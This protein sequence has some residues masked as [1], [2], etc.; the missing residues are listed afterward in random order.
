MTFFIITQVIV[1][2]KDDEFKSLLEP[3]QNVARKFKGKV[4]TLYIEA[5]KASV[6]FCRVNH[7]L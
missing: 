1:F 2:A 7:G 5:A 3:L 4:L 6:I